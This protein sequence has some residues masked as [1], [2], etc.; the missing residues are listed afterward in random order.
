MGGAG[1]AL[2][3]VVKAVLLNPLPYPEPGRIG[4]IAEVNDAGKQTQVA[5]R[6]FLDWQEQNHSFAV[7]A[8]YEEG[9]ATVTS[10]ARAEGVRPQ[11]MGATVAALQEAGLVGGAP[12]PARAARHQGDPLLFR[13]VSCHKKNAGPDFPAA[14]R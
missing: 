12:D 3:S 1:A 5:L 4:W 8:A 14:A 10:L 13:R 7:M 6:N 11:S 9:P 2:F